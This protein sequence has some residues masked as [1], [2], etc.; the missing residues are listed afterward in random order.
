MIHLLF[1]QAKASRLLCLIIV[2]ASVSRMSQAATTADFSYEASPVVDNGTVPYRLYTAKYYSLPANSTKKYPLIIWFHGL[3]ERGTNNTAQLSNGVLNIANDTNQAHEPAFVMVPQ[4]PTDAGGWTSSYNSAIF[5]AETRLFL[6]IEDLKTRFRIDPDRIYLMGLSYGGGGT[7][8]MGTRFPGYFAAIA[9]MSMSGNGAKESLALMDY[10]P[11]WAF[12]AQDDSYHGATQSTVDAVRAVGGR[13]IFT[14]YLTGGHTSTTWGAAADDPDFYKWLMS[15]RR[16]GPTAPTS[17]LVR[18]TSPSATQGFSTTASSA[19]FSGTAAFAG[20]TMTG[21]TA[22][23]WTRRSGGTTSATTALT[24]G[25][26]WSAGI[27]S[28]N[29]E[30]NL[31]SFLATASLNSSTTRAGVSTFN[32]AI[33]INDLAA[34]TL[35]VSNPTTA[36]THVSPTDFLTIKGSATDNH[37]VTRISWS[38]DRGGNGVAGADFENELVGGVN[39]FVRNIPLQPGHN[40][41]TVVANDLA[42]N[43]DTK[44]LDVVRRPSR[45]GDFFRQDFDSSTNVADYKTLSK[46]PGTGLFGDIAAQS[47]GG[48]WSIANGMLQ[49]VRPGGTSNLVAG[50]TRGYTLDGPPAGVAVISFDIALPGSPNVFTAL[51][52]FGL[53]LYL[54]SNDVLTWGAGYVNRNT[55]LD[56]KGAGT[57]KFKFAVNGVPTVTFQSDGTIYP[58]KWFVNSSSAGQSYLAPDSTTHTVNSNC[59]DLWVGTQKVLSNAAKNPNYKSSYLGCFNFAMNG[60]DALTLRLDNLAI[61]DFSVATPYLAWK[62]TRFGGNAS[63]PEISGDLADPDGNGRCNLLDYALSDSP[64]AGSAPVTPAV[65]VPADRLQMALTRPASMDVTYIVEAS[66]DLATWAPIARLHS[67]SSSWTGTAAVTESGTG[68]TRNVIVEDPLPISAQQKR[69]LRLRIT[70]P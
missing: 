56:I 15:Q 5:L 49:L 65:R 45:G 18:V 42:G 38:N 23:G 59:S 31:I 24:P 14:S 37:C 66:N 41:I 35:T 46:S 36:S 54:G 30:V 60:T 57:N 34:P 62:T 16:L 7:W 43:T 68:A 51:G 55:E 70:N 2:L 39:W 44:T 63:N 50:F 47:D 10:L 6:A 12:A 20:S 64:T 53:G 32:D 11:I 22:L 29:P 21:F 61:S 8:N 4:M 58:V 19:A 52:T 48:I 1:P 13:A 40:I 27:L 17:P 25:T 3:G 9:P 28:I 69:F 26:T 67:N 33:A